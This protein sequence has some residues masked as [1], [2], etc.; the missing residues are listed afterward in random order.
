MQRYR[1]KHLVLVE[2]MIAMLVWAIVLPVLAI[3]LYRESVQCKLVMANAA[4]R[5]LEKILIQEASA[6]TFFEM[7]GIHYH[8]FDD[9]R[10][11]VATPE[12]WFDLKHIHDDVIASGM[13]VKYR[14]KRIL[15]TP[16]RTSEGAWK[17]FIHVECTCFDQYH[18]QIYFFVFP[19]VL[20]KPN[21]DL[22]EVR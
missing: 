11:N 5:R 1:R 21:I 8:Y 20:I 15:Q 7:A 17:R 9:N 12:G 14:M 16:K 6:V 4:C 22:V 2:L 19:M 3:P 13:T 10:T 18:D